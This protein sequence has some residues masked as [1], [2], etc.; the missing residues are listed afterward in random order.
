MSATAL[1]EVL[2][3]SN[4]DAEVRK[5]LRE[6]DRSALTGFDLTKQEIEA[7]FQGD[8]EAIYR[9]IDD[10]DYHHIRENGNYSDCLTDD[11]LTV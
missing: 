7:L 8:E 10:T 2:T 6:R 9:L 5:G 3:K 4:T 1:Q 11:G